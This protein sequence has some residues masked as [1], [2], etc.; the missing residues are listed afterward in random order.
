MSV[1]RVTTPFLKGVLTDIN[2]IK[3]EP[4]EKKAITKYARNERVY[5]GLLKEK[6]EKEQKFIIFDTKAPCLSRPASLYVNGGVRKEGATHRPHRMEE[7]EKRGKKPK[8]GL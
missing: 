1:T 5:W 8:K 2:D 6:M 7:R 3:N 4:W